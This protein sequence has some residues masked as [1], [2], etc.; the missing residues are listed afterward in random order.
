MKA[1]LYI[2]NTCIKSHNLIALTNKFTK[3]KNKRSYNNLK[4]DKQ[5]LIKRSHVSVI[6]SIVCSVY[7]QTNV[8][9]TR[10]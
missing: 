3:K 5:Q 1:P 2:S 4:N 6:F 8:I 9:D 7:V 10:L